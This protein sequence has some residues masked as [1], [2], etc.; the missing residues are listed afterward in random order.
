M[1]HSDIVS[2]HSHFGHQAILILPILSR[3]I[4]FVLMLFPEAHLRFSL[5]QSSALSIVYKLEVME[6]SF[7]VSVEATV[8]KA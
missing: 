5:Q 4:Q 8:T 6:V 3:D 1:F 7:V 2:R